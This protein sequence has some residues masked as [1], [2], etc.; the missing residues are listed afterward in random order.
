MA[1]RS[2]VTGGGAPDIALSVDGRPKKV[3]RELAGH[4]FQRIRGTYGGGSRGVSPYMLARFYR[5]FEARHDTLVPFR[6]FVGEWLTKISPCLPELF[7]DPAVPG[8]ALREFFRGLDAELQPARDPAE[9]R[10][11]EQAP[12][13]TEAGFCRWLQVASL[14][15]PAQEAARLARVSAAWPTVPDLWDLDARPPRDGAAP[16]GG[17]AQSRSSRSL[18]RRQLERSRGVRPGQATAAAELSAAAPA[19]AAA[20]PP[21]PPPAVSYAAPPP[22]PRA[23]SRS[24]S[25]YVDERGPRPSSRGTGRPRVAPQEWELPGF[26]GLATWGAGPIEGVASTGGPGAGYPVG[27]ELGSRTLR[28]GGRG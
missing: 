28:W 9:L 6:D 8:W 4:I 18:L 10:E 21:P 7:E 23:R 26:E 13:L 16:D 22:R 14:A 12:E 25:S 15:Y 20:P 2:P 3:F 1:S 27:G 19:R 17:H 24:R 5:R 11:E